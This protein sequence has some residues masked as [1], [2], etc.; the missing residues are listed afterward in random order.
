[1]GRHVKGT[2]FVD[3]VRMLRSR[4]DL[5]R[6]RYL[7]PADIPYLT[8]RIHPDAWYPM[9]TFA[10]FGLAILDQVAQ[11]DLFLVRAWGRASVDPLVRIHSGLLV[12]G[13][14]RESLMRFLVLRSSFFD[15]DA[16]SIPLLSDG[17]ASLHVHYGMISRAEQAACFQTLGFFGRLVELA[18]GRGVLT[19][20]TQ[21]AWEGDP[22][23]VLAID[24]TPPAGHV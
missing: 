2:I 14:P 12:E 10:R 5:D 19:S 16:V 1:M 4:K 7:E 6:N 17:H 13:D 21:R 18:G 23:T 15:F 24:W 3:Y 20:L 11:G 22:A 8:S 9:E